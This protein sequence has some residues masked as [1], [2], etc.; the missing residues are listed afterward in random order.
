MSLG[1]DSFLTQSFVLE[2]IH[3]ISTAN[4]SVKDNYAH[5]LYERFLDRLEAKKIPFLVYFD[6][7]SYQLELPLPQA[8]I[9]TVEDAS[10][11]IGK[12][13]IDDTAVSHSTNL[14]GFP[15]LANSVH[16]GDMLPPLDQKRN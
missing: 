2:S 1:C 11:M 7:E 14:S 12:G 15:T 9:F 3:E 13:T 6:S 10:Q 16:G 8:Y 5:Q 4:A